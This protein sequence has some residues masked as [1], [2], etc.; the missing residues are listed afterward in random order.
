MGFALRL[1]ERMKPYY[2][3]AG[4]LLLF[5][6]ITPG[7]TTEEMAE[8]TGKDCSTCHLDP[9]GG[10]ELTKAGQEYLKAISLMT[11]DARQESIPPSRKKKLRLLRFI[12]GYLHIFMAIFWFGTILYVHIILKP[13]YAAHGLPRGEVRLGLVS[14][15]IMAVTG[16]ILTAFRIPSL[17]FLIKTRFGILLLLKIFLFLIMVGSTFFVVVFIGP[18]LGKKRK[19]EPLKAKGKF[20]LDEL[21]AFDGTEGR[22]SYIAF[23]NGIYD[24]SQS[25]YW[26]GG[27][28]FVRHEAGKDLTD[29]LTY[30]PHGEEK[31]L[32]LPHE[33]ELVIGEAMKTFPP[34]EKMFYI[35][36]YM[37]LGMVVLITL[38]L[39]LW[40]WW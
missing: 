30:A 27:K 14:M 21:S 4:I 31:I 6:I 29:Q 28:H 26:E 24:V 7:S 10:G 5:L 13:S 17:S 8:R 40:R 38:I 32:D 3:L 9:S 22:P 11:G 39:A 25:Q 23:K 35:I 2:L 18:K 1:S 33:G 37:N 20:T 36:A 16:V 34:A 19:T 12:V 15:A